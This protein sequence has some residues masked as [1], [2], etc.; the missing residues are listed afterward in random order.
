MSR[1]SAVACGESSL[2]Y[3]LLLWLAGNR[4][5]DTLGYR[6][7]QPMRCGLRGIVARIHS[8]AGRARR[9]RRCGLRGIVAR[10]HYARSALDQPPAVACGESSLGYTRQLAAL[11]PAWLWLAGNRRSDTL[12]AATASTASCGL[13]GIVARIHCRLMHD[14]PRRC[15]LRGI[16]ARIHLRVC[17]LR[18]ADGCGLRG[19]AARIHCSGSRRP[20]ESGLWLA[21]NRRS[22]TLAVLG[23]AA[24]RLWLAGNRRSDT[25]DVRL[26]QL[27]L[28]WLA[29]N[30]RSD[31]LCSA[32]APV[33]VGCGLR[34][35]A[36]RI[37]SGQRRPTH[38]LPLWLAGNRRSDTLAVVGQRSALVAVACG[39]SPL[40]YTVDVV[41]TPRACCGLRGIAARIHFSCR[42]WPCNGIAV[43][44]GESSL[45]YTSSIVGMHAAVRLW[46]A[47]NR[48]SDTLVACE[49]EPVLW[50]AGNRRSDT[51]ARVRP[52]LP[53]AVACGESPLGYTIGRAGPLRCSCGLRGI[54]ARIHSTGRA[55]AAVACGESPLGYT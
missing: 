31:T 38:E 13:R 16:A 55:C 37:H 43:A 5:S 50:L 46:L 54:A 29:G 52:Y 6:F 48:R 27:E 51:L 17:R 4:R 44:C 53:P 15:G 7:G 20:A 40:G 14:A 21:G 18:P 10:I 33:A 28:L 39:E 47:G 3:T 34:G 12:P 36:A 26:P 35:I 24:P 1:N 49:P 32:D 8:Q 22:D 9:H 23:S 19:I 25:L 42:A 45:G 2:G 30:R 41:A 11:M